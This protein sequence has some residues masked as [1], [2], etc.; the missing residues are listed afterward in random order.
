MLET[1][2]FESLAVLMPLQFRNQHRYPYDVTVSDG[3]TMI[4]A[5]FGDACMREFE[6]KHNRKFHDRTEGGVIAIQDYDLVIIPQLEGIS[7]D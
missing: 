4:H 6:K 2:L 7:F 5:S 3:T 1:R